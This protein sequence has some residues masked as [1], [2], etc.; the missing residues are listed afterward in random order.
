VEGI[1]TA[2]T[3]GSVVLGQG[4]NV[5]VDDLFVWSKLLD[6]SAVESLYDFYK[7]NLK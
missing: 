5:D 1:Y 4:G 2:N 6:L 3:V 7:G